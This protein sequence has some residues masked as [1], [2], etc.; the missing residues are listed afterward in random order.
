MHIRIKAL[1]KI[2]G[3]KLITS[4]PLPPEFVSIKI[5]GALRCQVANLGAWPMRALANPAVTA[6]FTRTESVKAWNLPP[7]RAL[8]MAEFPG[9][10]PE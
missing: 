1:G 5:P 6:G 10:L 9:T 4:L 2:P 8:I 7:R 3:N